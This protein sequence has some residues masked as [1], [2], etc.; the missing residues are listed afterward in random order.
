MLSCER[1]RNYLYSDT[2]ESDASSLSPRRCTKEVDN[3]A[4]FALDE[5]LEELSLHGSC[6]AES[7]WGDSNKPP[8]GRLRRESG[9]AP[10]ATEKLHFP[11]MFV[12]EFR[13]GHVGFNIPGVLRDS[14]KPTDS[15]DLHFNFELGKSRQ[16][17]GGAF[18]PG[19]N[20]PLLEQGPAGAAQSRTA[21]DCFSNRQADS[22]FM[23]SSHAN[24]NQAGGDSEKLQQDTR[25]NPVASN[26]GDVGG[27]ACAPFS[28][29]A[30]HVR[31]GGNN[32]DSL[33]GAGVLISADSGLPPVTE[34]STV[35]CS[36]RF[37]TFSN[38][39]DVYWATSR[40]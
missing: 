34:S 30:H 38:V 36:T 18:T 15:I 11:A 40:P 14:L 20:H 13:G 12:E 39:S 24:D 9:V 26:C 10:K 37:S 21:G 33:I 22:R 4:L 7:R 2:E 32:A 1:Y 29:A 28:M 3:D 23:F 6:S 8:L 5:Q 19:T 17:E 25:W 27:S 35:S 16:D 31:G